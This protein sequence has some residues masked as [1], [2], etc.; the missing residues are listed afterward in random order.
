MKSTAL[1]LPTRCLCP[2]LSV[3]G[4]AGISA[5]PRRPVQPPFPPPMA[6]FTATRPS[7]SLRIGSGASGPMA[8]TARPA[9]GGRCVRV[10]AWAPGSATRSSSSRSNSWPSRPRSVRHGERSATRWGPGHDSARAGVGAGPTL[11]PLCRPRRH[12]G[13]DRQRG[14]RPALVP[15]PEGGRV[16]GAR[17]PADARDQP[18]LRPSP[19]RH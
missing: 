4:C 2:P 6:R 11:T 7:R 13:W 1:A 5:P 18:A 12:H 16:C 15:G 9:L 17:R 3:G 8:L 14:A 10:H 19:Q